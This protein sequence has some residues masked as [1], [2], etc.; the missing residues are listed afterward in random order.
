[1]SEKIIEEKV[2][3]ATALIWRVLLVAERSFRKLDHPQLL[4][5]VADGAKCQNGIRVVEK[6][7]TSDQ[8]A[9]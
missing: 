4:A 7:N 8:E 3:N 6:V 2:V 5:E 1:V 9:A